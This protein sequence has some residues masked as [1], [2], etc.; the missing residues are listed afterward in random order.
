MRTFLELSLASIDFDVL[1]RI[2]TKRHT[3]ARIKELS[4]GGCLAQYSWDTG[5]PSD[6]ILVVHLFFCFLAERMPD[7]SLIS[8][9]YCGKDETPS[10]SLQI[11]LASKNPPHF[12]VCVETGC[13]WD[14]FP[15]RNNVFQALVLF[16]YVINRNGGYILGLILKLVED[17]L[18]C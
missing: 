6:S 2:N 10:G 7:A 1:K 15:K 4:R 13:V 17:I 8:K 16:A 18:V 14:V 5:D 12:Q 9:Y 3:L 11:R